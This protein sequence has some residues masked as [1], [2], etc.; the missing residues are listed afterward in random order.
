MRPEIKVSS[1]VTGQ[2]CHSC[3]KGQIVIET[4]SRTEQMPLTWFNR[5]INRFVRQETSEVT[6]SE[7]RIYCNACAATFAFMPPVQIQEPK[8]VA[9]MAQTKPGLYSTSKSGSIWQ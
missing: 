2:I 5:L 6:Y 9:G 3:H 8:V 1:Q 4:S 7:D